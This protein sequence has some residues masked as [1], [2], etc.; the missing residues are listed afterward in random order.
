ME[1][2]GTR[3]E[4]TMRRR[5]LL[6][7]QIDSLPDSVVEKVLEFVSFQRYSLGLFDNDTDYLGSIP[8]MAE[9]IVQGMKTPVHECFETL[10]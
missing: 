2:S 10:E 9:S 7:T 6:M 8:G 3:G 1:P 5:E 4:E